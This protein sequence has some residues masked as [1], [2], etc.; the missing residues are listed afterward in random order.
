MATFDLIL[1]SH[2]CVGPQVSQQQY[3]TPIMYGANI[4]S[5]LLLIAAAAHDV[6][7]DRT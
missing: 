2:E 5:H 7:N 4:T 3:T 6:S 1:A